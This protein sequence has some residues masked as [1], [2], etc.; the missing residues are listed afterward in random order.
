MR[1]LR[2]HIQPERRGKHHHS[3]VKKLTR[4]EKQVI[5][6]KEFVA[7]ESLRKLPVHMVPSQV[8]RT[9]AFVPVVALCFVNFPNALIVVVS[10]SAAFLLALPHLA[11]AGILWIICIRVARLVGY[12]GKQGC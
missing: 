9:P 4:T 7:V 11:H 3:V 1:V 10:A 8:N 6:A 2:C 12:M 5:F